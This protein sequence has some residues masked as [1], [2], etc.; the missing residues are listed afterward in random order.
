MKFKKS[1]LDQIIKEELIAVIAES[2]END[3]SENIAD[4]AVGSL[5]QLLT[6]KPVL[7]VFNRMKTVLDSQGEP[8]SPSRKEEIAAVL[9]AL[10][11]TS[12]DLIKIVSGMKGEEKNQ[13]EQSPDVG[14]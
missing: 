13:P 1:K 10:G 14:L 6:K 2:L 9:G 4:R 5:K 8:G 12:V 11:I 3:I 7:V